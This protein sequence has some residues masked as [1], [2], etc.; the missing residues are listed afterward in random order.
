MQALQQTDALFFTQA[1]L[2]LGRVQGVVGDA[3]HGMEDGELFLEY[4]RSENFVFDDGKLKTAQTDTKQGFGLRGVVGEATGLAHATSLDEAAIRRAAQT[5]RAVKTGYDG[6]VAA[7]PQDPARTNR[8][9][10]H[11]ANPLEGVAFAEKIALLQQIDAYARNKDPHNKNI[12]VAQVTVNLAASWQAIQILRASG[13][14]YADVRPLVRLN[15]S[16]ILRDGTR[17]ESGWAG[18]GGREAYGRFIAPAYWQAMVD[19]AFAM[20][21]ANLASVEAPAGETTVVL[22]PGWTGILLHEAVGHGL[23]GDF[24]RKGTS[25]FT[26]LL[27]S[28]VAAAGVTVVDDGAMDNRR[29]SLTIDDE[30]TPSQRT[31]LIDDGILVGYMQDRLN[32]RLMGGASTGNGRR[33]SFAHKPMPRMTNT[34]MLSGSQSPESIIASVKNGI[35][36]AQFGGGQVDIT[37]GKFVFSAQEAYKIE[38]GVITQPIKGATLIGSGADAL[39]RISMVG[40]DSA[41][42]GGIGT[43]GKDGQSVP[44]GVGQPTIRIDAMTVGGAG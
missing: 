43:C 31:P 39:K 9:L 30:G 4:R 13:A 11:A 17:Q 19:K 28:R 10:Y 18:G 1:G 5:V 20:A 27:G 7:A 3:L 37:S 26:S 42:D 2:D 44:V 6:V 41:L 35:Y 32:G 21:Q 16:V 14:R 8:S 15:I 23:E 38:N 34:S 29:G 36:A 24:N 25:V 33:E 40:N 12:S 22:G